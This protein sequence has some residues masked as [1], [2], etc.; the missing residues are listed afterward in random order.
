MEMTS[1]TMHEKPLQKIRQLV[2][3][4]HTLGELG[5]RI[6]PLSSCGPISHEFPFGGMMV[7]GEV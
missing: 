7:A 1:V 5:F 4:Q 2:C 6:C 3:K